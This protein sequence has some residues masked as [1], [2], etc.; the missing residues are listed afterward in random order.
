MIPKTTEVSQWWDAPSIA[1]SS[2]GGIRPDA[3]LTRIYLKREES[4]Y[5]YDL[6]SG[7]TGFENA[8][9]PDLQNGDQIYLASGGHE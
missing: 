4:I 8:Q 2:A 1:L 3:D 9:A 6:S 5:Q 7:I